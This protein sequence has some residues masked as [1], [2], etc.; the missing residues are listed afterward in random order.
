M[1]IF[2]ELGNTTLKLAVLEKERYQFLGSENYHTDVQNSFNELF[3]H[4]FDNVSNVYVCSVASADL[5]A[6]LTQYIHQTFQIYPTFLAT[7][8]ESCGLVCGYDRFESL[9]VDRWMAMIGACAH[10]SQPTIIVDAGTALTVDMVIDKKHQGGFIVPG[11]GL[12]KQS[13]FDRTAIPIVTDTQPT[14]V[15]ELLAK[16]TGRAITGGTLF[17]LSAFLNTL[18]DNL[19]EETGL[20]FRYIGTGGDFETLNPMLDKHFEVIPDLTLIGMVEMIQSC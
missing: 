10:S 19:E 15:T 4:N 7:Q 12:M 18:A 2:I 6:A 20:R 14:V 8:P 5:N 16:D 17:M 3:D 9:G 11:L 1:K 13:L